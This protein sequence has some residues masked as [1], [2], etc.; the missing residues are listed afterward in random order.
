MGETVRTRSY[1]DVLV[2]G[3]GKTAEAVADYLMT[4]VA[5][6]RVR[7]VTVYA[8]L[9]SGPGPVSERLV[10]SGVRV[11]FGT[12]DIEGC[13]DT[14]V[15]SP[16]ISQASDFWLSAAAHSADIFGEPE[17]A[18]RESPE[19]WVGVTGT[20]GKTTTTTLVRDLLRSGGL[21]A[22]AVG[23]IGTVAISE[24]ARRTP[25]EWLVAELSS[26]QLAGT[27]ELHPRVA[28][29]LNVTPDH[30]AWHAT[31]QNYAAAK[32]RI[33]ANLTATDLAVVSDGD[34]WCRAAATRCAQRG[35]RVCR[36][37]AVGE[38]PE[39]SEAY[40]AWQAADGMLCVRLNGT[41]VRLVDA[42]ELSIRGTHNVENALAAASAALECGVAPQRVRAALVAFQALEHRIE[43]CGELGGIHFVNDSK[44]T[45]ADAVCKALTAFRAGSVVILL[46]GHDKGTDL[47][48]MAACVARTARLAVCYGEAGPR[49]AQALRATS[50]SVEVAQASH[51]AQA[52]DIAVRSA[53]PG[54]TV[55]LSPACSSFDEFCSF[56]ERGE[57]FKRL[58]AARLMAGERT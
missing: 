35:I 27:C 23:N 9:E 32:E 26:F 57:T 55:L 47:A 7:S 21:T 4:L 22:A 38:S 56:E 58:V 51:L 42:R 43:P 3:L 46:G 15:S 29:L 20:N 45:N 31:M 34:A 10:R 13:Y 11:V 44:A 50:E 16:G 17:L 52:F 5:L 18:W 8:G 30:L 36:V 19:R 24:V 41:D 2:L 6:G 1:G 25:D 39:K 54:E 48:E 28:I 53:L 12:Q 37:L 14:C 40:A 33:F 49:I